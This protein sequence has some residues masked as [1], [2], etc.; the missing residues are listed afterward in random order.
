MDCTL[1]IMSFK[2][3]GNTD[4][5]IN[6]LWK[7]SLIIF[8]SAVWEK[9]WQSTAIPPRTRLISSEKDMTVKANYWH[10]C[11]ITVP[12]LSWVPCA[13]LR[14]GLALFKPVQWR[15]PQALPVILGSTALKM[16]ACSSAVWLPRTK[17]LLLS[18]KQDNVVVS[19]VGLQNYS[20]LVLTTQ[21]HFV[22]KRVNSWSGVL[23]WNI[24]WI[25]TRA[26]VFLYV[27]VNMFKQASLK[28]DFGF[29]SR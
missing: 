12:P 23:H 18:A 21:N 20:L 28:L 16:L 7:H 27:S 25:E 22:W 3:F 5:F 17:R 24:A 29:F 4:G 2:C 1:L 9:I 15:L 19:K 11:G 13:N 26:F 8:A 10:S 14:T 6:M